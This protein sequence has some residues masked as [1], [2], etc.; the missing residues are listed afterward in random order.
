MR[1]TPIVGIALTRRAPRFGVVMMERPAR[2]KEPGVFLTSLQISRKR[3]PNVF[4][5][6]ETIALV[7]E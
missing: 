5:P 4:D 6:I 2:L 3:L 1:D 7:F